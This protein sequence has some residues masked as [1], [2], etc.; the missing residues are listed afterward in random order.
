MRIDLQIYKINR[1]FVHKWFL[2]KG[3]G[4]ISRSIS[5]LAIVTGCPCIVIAY[6]LGEITNWPSDVIYSI[7]ALKQFYG[8][9]EI[10]NTPT[11]TPSELLFRR[12][13]VL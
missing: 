2:E 11:N 10:L 6:W 3:N 4:D 12:E 8:Y 9:S 5:I 7:Q 1:E 13:E